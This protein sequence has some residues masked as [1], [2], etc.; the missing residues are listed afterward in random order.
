MSEVPGASTVRPEHSWPVASLERYLATSPALQADFA[1]V[2]IISVLQF[3]GGQSNPTFY[4]K[5]S[6][7]Q[8]LV[9]RK[10][11][12]GKLLAT[13]HAIEREYVILQALSKTEVP[14]PL[15][16]VFCE[17]SSVIG[18]PFY[19]MQYIRGRVFRDTHL[20]D[21]SQ[22][23]RKQVYLAMA[24][25]LAKLHSVDHVKVGL[26]GFGN[27]DGFFERQISRWT[28]QYKAAKIEDIEPMERLSV[29][30]PQHI[31]NSSGSSIVH[32]DFRIDNLVF[33]PSEPR[34]IA[35]LD[36]ELCTIG[37][38]LADVAYSC[39]HYNMPTLPPPLS[40]M[41]G[42]GRQGPSELGIP[43]QLEYV[44]HYCRCRGIER[45]TNL[46]FYTAFGLF[47]LASILVGVY[48]RGVE[49]N[50][51]SDNAKRMGSFAELLAT[52]AMRIATDG[53][54]IPLWMSLFPFSAKSKA[55]YAEVS[56]FMR[57]HVIP[58]E[59]VIH[60]H[61]NSELR[62]TVHP[63]IEQLKLKAK[64]A[65][66]WNLFLPSSHGAGLTN[67]DYAP[68]CE[69]MGH[70]LIAP[71]I[72][73]C[74][75]PDTGNMEVL[76]KYGTA[77]QKATWLAP[78]LR[79]EIRSAFAMTEPGVASSDA[80]N[81]ST[82]IIKDGDSYIVTGRKWWTTGAGHPNCRL[83]IVMGKS[84]SSGPIH[85]R[86]SMILVPRDAPGV[87]VV[88]PLKTFGYDDAPYGHC[89]VLF[90]NVRV[91]ATNILLGEGRGFEI[92]QGRLG[93]GRIHHC[94]RLI[95]LSERSLALM[96]HRIQS[97]STFGKKISEHG[98][99]MKDVALS[100]TE[101]DQARLLTLQAAH[102]MDSV[103]N[104]LA[105]D[106]IAA[107]KI[108]APRVACRVVDRAIQAFGAAGMSED[109]FL[110]RA[111]AGARSLRLADGPDEVH[112][113]TLAKIEYS[114]HL[115]SKI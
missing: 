45:Q 17:D 48:R 58:A 81:I 41:S 40:T 78:L 13:A 26:Q 23:E 50:A 102:A 21:L 103:G 51:S 31:P 12:P 88:R 80:T 90:E 106:Q 107:I 77:D 36:W 92:A 19:I 67:L 66:L 62:W 112:E 70:S 10:K 39:L 89:E 1:E 11:P 9:L 73:N 8:E 71:E 6:L 105:R 43:T 104:Q 49:G 5:T 94:M 91:P 7:G 24:E 18:T 32:G 34:V 35:V 68:L 54:T 69:L 46:S 25:V 87:S 115:Q 109:F 74:N 15:P 33:H 53:S 100:R 95:G 37:H 61:D 44:E 55:L 97:R 59:Q 56:T 30:L 3:K 82:S 111:Y 99:I 27:P 113:Q 72:F 65:G 86:Q 85:R 75:A 108:V 114:K 38:P 29:W 4:L 98:K 93:P 47:R 42:F 83:F 14:V 79:G 52:K 20:P 28:R 2:K 110:A 64:E 57:D 84:S 16:V 60:A 76:E 96:V 22:H 101:I 63:L